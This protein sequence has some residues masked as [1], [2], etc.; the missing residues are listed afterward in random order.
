MLA[1]SLPLDTLSLSSPS[2]THFSCP[3][4]QFGDIFMKA[5]I[6]TNALPVRVCMYGGE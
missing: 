2:V 6:E 3:L 5:G 1:G 4:L